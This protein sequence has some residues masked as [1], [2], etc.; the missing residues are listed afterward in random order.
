[1]KI[2]FAASPHRTVEQANYYHL[3]MDI[4]WFGLALPATTRFLSV[5]AIHL[6]ADVTVLTW[7]ASLPA[8]IL[9][10]AASL[11]NW[12][13]RRHSSS[14]SAVFWPALGFRLAFLLPAL[15]PFLPANFQSIWLILS[16]ALPAL[17]QGL[18]SV[19]FLVMFREAVD[20]KQVP[21][22]LSRRSLALNMAVGLSGLALGAWLERAPFPFNYQAMFLLAFARPRRDRVAETREGQCA[23]GLGR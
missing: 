13:M 17:P 16:L 8:F 5:Y 6:G 15:T 21:P 10:F 12:W 9:L 18:A 4:A 11:G 19:A 20:D 23:R 3:V 14:A 2:S 1:M 22:L 7:L